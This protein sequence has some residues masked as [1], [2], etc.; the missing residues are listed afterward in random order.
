VLTARLPLETSEPV[1]E[2]GTRVFANLAAPLS[3]QL[4][5]FVL[6]GNHMA[7]LLNA[8]FM[9]WIGVYGCPA[10]RTASGTL[11]GLVDCYGASSSE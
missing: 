7:A 9:S 2:M 11:D 5:L 1:F 6:A 3:P 10:A 4:W 8:V